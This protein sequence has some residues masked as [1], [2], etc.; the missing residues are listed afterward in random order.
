MWADTMWADTMW[1]DTMW[2]DTMWADAMWA[3]AKWSALCP[4]CSCL[5]FDL[6]AEDHMVLEQEHVALP[7]LAEQLAGVPDLGSGEG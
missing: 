5:V 7:V 2:A 3:N 1:A 4:T 6:L